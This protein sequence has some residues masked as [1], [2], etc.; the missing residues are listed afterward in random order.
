MMAVL[1]DGKV[2]NGGHPPGFA[3]VQNRWVVYTW[4]VWFSHEVC[5]IYLLILFPGHPV[6]T[7]W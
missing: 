6:N 5:A 3:W 2:D 1:A 7:S 4:K